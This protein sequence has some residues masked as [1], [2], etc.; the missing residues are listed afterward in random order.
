MEKPV[1]K[2]V[3]IE[4]EKQNFTSMKD[5]FQLKIYVLIK[6]Q[7]LI[8]SL[9]VKKDLNILLATKMKKKQTFKYISPKME[10]YRRDFDETKYIFFDER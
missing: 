10:A 3:N 8:R 9:S 7:Y 6:Q 4:K 1:V 5:L 2:F